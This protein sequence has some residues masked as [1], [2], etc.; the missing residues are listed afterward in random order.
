MPSEKW[1]LIDGFC[2]WHTKGKASVPRTGTAALPHAGKGLRPLHGR[3]TNLFYLPA[4]A[5]LVVFTV[6]PLINGIQLSLTNWD[7]YSPDREFVGV[8]N[9]LRLLTGRR[10]STDPAQHPHLWVRQHADPAGIGPGAGDDP[11]QAVARKTG[12][13]GHHLP[14]RAGLA[15]S[16]GNHV[17]PDF[18]LQQRHPQQHRKR[19]R[20]SFDLVAEQRDAG[21]DRDRDR[22]LPPVRRR[23]HGHLSSRSPIHSDRVLRGGGAGR[24]LR[25][26]SLCRCHGATS[27]TRL[28]PPASS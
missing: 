15:S 3:T 26:E 13:A 17:L 4:I 1:T 12:A 6:Y 9:Y 7:G 16:H 20:R 2:N 11:Q 24:G 27:P 18:R 21:C 25:M 19:P 22:E 5:L 8:A 10:L 23:L 28:R 14:T